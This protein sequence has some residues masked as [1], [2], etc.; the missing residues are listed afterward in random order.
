MSR[1]IRTSCRKQDETRV[2]TPKEARM[3]EENDKSSGG[4]TKKR[5]LENPIGGRTPKTRV[6]VNT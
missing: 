4:K 6:K 2:D 1:K 5:S 3:T